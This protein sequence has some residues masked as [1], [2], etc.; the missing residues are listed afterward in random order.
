MVK[1]G[2]IWSDKYTDYNLGDSH[3][4]NP[5]RLIIPYQLFKSLK[6]FDMPEIQA[7]NPQPVPKPYLNR[8]PPI[9]DSTF[10]ALTYSMVK[11]T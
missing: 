11:E 9:S 1:T 8:A 10:I 5:K 4:M 6:I 3:P 2:I 7:F